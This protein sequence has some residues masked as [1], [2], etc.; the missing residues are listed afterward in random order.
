MDDE[1]PVDM[2]RE[3]PLSFSQLAKRFRVK[4]RR[5][6]CATLA[7]L[8]GSHDCKDAK[9]GRQALWSQETEHPLALA[10]GLRR[11]S[12]RQQHERKASLA[13]NQHAESYQTNFSSIPAK[14]AD[15]SGTQ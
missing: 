12:N 4:G 8:N 2:I 14:R 1:F 5:P 15:S 13:E 7:R 9:N 3:A 6:H 10:R 11:A